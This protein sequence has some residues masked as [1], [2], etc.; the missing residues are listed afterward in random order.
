MTVG[1]HM[2]E[3]R[4]KAGLT[5]AQLA[6]KSGVATISI[7]QYETGKRTPRL[8]QL[9]YIA[10]ALE[11]D[12]SEFASFASDDEDDRTKNYIAIRFAESETW[13]SRLDEIGKDLANLN[14]KGQLE[15][16]K[17]VKELTEIEK[18]RYKQ[19]P[20]PLSAGIK[21]YGDGPAGSFPP[22]PQ[23]P[24]TPPAPQE[25]K[26]TTPPPEGAEGPGEGE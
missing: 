10:S 5:Q 6:E 9:V 4:K 20:S 19:K 8:E 25:G 21:I 2:R 14:D 13:R 22:A 23:P 12:P 7:H 1:E 16:V 11:I 24:Q 3:A 26:D 17:R 15:A 18:Y